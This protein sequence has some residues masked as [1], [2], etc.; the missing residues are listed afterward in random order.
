MSKKHRNTPVPAEPADEEMP[1][2]APIAADAATDVDA[3]ESTPS[4]TLEPEADP[5][6]VTGDEGDVEQPEIDSVDGLGDAAEL[7]PVAA[8]EAEAIIEVTLTLRIDCAL[9]NGT[10]PRGT[11]L[12]KVTVADGINP[13]EFIQI[14]RNENCGLQADTL[15]DGRVELSTI[16][17]I[18]VDGREFPAKTKIAIAKLEKNTIVQE[19]INALRGYGTVI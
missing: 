18:A 15:A 19:V 1:G 4:E 7:P 13:S 16:G 9:G 5:D 11:S 2:L 17:L 10:K 6:E 3:G 12:G 14:V 8:D